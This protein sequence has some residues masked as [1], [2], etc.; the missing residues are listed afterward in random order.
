MSVK[1]WIK[2]Y[3]SIDFNTTANASEI[4]FD[5]REIKKKPVFKYLGILVDSKLSFVSHTEEVKR[6]LSKQCGVIAKLRHFVLWKLLK[7]Y[8]EANIRPIVQYGILVYACCSY[9]A[10]LPMF[11]LKKMEFIFFKKKNWVIW[12]HFLK[13]L[14]IDCLWSARLW[15]NYI[16]FQGNQW[17]SLWGFL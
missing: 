10:L 4:F 16:R 14:H 12:R 7:H 17:P 6:K 15:N 13:A 5:S 8:Y 3:R 2:R 1:I 9:S 11:L